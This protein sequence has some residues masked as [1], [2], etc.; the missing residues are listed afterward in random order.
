[1]E[2][3]TYDAIDNWH[4]FGALKN[5]AVSR[6]RGAELSGSI[7]EKTYDDLD[8]TWPLDKQYDLVALG[9]CEEGEVE[10]LVYIPMAELSMTD[11]SGEVGVRVRFCSTGAYEP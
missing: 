5:A 10:I 2:N 11:L 9:Q 8:H 6:H 3:A 7:I 4:D 1:M